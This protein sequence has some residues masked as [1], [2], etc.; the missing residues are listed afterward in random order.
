[1]IDLHLSDQAPGIQR[2]IYTDILHRC[3]S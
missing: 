1:M 2:R 3:S